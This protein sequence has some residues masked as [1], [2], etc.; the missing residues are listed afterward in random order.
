MGSIWG[1]V[2]MLPASFTL[3]LALSTPPTF[4][5]PALED[6]LDDM[7]R[8]RGEA[9]QLAGKTAVDAVGFGELTNG[10]LP[11]LQQPL[12]PMRQR[13]HAVPASSG[14]GIDRVAARI[15]ASWAQDVG[16][17]TTIEA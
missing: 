7:Q 13:Q 10:A 17:G 2:Q 1:L 15:A 8:Q 5:R 9:Q 12:Q 3:S 16:D 11:V 6:R 14:I 4:G